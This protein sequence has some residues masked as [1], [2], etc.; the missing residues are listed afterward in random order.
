MRL[1]IQE[2]RVGEEIEVKR[3]WERDHSEVVHVIDADVLPK[4]KVSRK[5]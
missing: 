2:V 3:A 4:L 5:N 1:R